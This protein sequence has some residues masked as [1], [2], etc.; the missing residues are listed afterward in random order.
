MIDH[1]IVEFGGN[2]SHLIKRYILNYDL[3]LD[4]KLTRPWTSLELN[5][6]AEVKNTRLL[7]YG[8]NVFGGR[9]SI[10]LSKQYYASDE[11]LMGFFWTL[12]VEYTLELMSLAA[13]ILAFVRNTYY[14]VNCKE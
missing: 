2:A 6:R 3:I 8:A 10:T 9:L 4:S 5:Y 1:T 12:K 11:I 13:F 14:I 7:P